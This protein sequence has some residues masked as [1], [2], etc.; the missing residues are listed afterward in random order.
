MKLMVIGCGGVATVAIHK[1]CE[2]PVFTEIL[3]ASRT[4]SKC[5]ALAEKLRSRTKAVITTATVNADRVESLTELMKKGNKIKEEIGCRST[6]NA[7]RNC[8]I[9]H[10]LYPDIFGKQNRDQPK[11]EK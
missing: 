7:C 3:I 9:L 2:N 6:C 5:D 11:K 1:C 10:G 8:A 4:K